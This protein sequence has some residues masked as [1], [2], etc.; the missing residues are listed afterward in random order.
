MKAEL[1][2]LEN[3]LIRERKDYAERLK[4][5]QKDVEKLKKEVENFEKEEFEEEDMKKK[6]KY[7]NSRRKKVDITYSGRPFLKYGHLDIDLRVFINQNDGLVPKIIRKKTMDSIARSCLIYVINNVKYVGDKIQTGA[8]EY[9]QFPFETLKSRKGD[10]EDGAILLANMM[11][12]SG[13]PY[14]RVRLNAGNVKGG[15]H[16]YVTYLADDDKWYILDWCYWPKES[17]KDF[18]VRPWEDRDDK[19]WQIWFSWNEK[20]CFYDKPVEKAKTI[21]RTFEL[22]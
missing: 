8:T 10:C 21:N 17:I 6:E 2:E 20:Y 22:K 3:T 9:W 15:G 12:R 18:L 16:A 19:Y 5:Y 14:W 11:L 1:E 4:Q 7:W 13:I